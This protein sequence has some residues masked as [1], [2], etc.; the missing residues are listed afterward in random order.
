MNPAFAS[1]SGLISACG[2][3]WVL[4]GPSR[5][6]GQTFVGLGGGWNYLPKAASD[7]PYR[8]GFNLTVS[9]GSSVGTGSR[10]RMDAFGMEYERQIT[11]PVPCPANGC[12]G[13]PS[14]RPAT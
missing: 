6:R 14:R 11:L 13:G 8:P 12:V 5:A 1:R 4:A 10:F 9:V 2:L 7:A 3:F